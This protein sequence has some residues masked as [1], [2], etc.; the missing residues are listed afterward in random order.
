MGTTPKK[1]INFFAFDF[2]HILLREKSQ[3]YAWTSVKKLKN[4]I[5]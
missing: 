2:F 3:A 1:Q 5:W 4:D